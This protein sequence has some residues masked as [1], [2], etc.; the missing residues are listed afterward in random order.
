MARRKLEGTERAEQRR[1]TVRRYRARL[2]A[3]GEPSDVII[4][5]PNGEKLEVFQKTGLTCKKLEIACKK[6]FRVEG[7]ISK[8]GGATEFLMMEHDIIIPGTYAYF[9]PPPAGGEC[10]RCDRCARLDTRCVTP[11]INAPHCFQCVINGYRCRRDGGA[12]E[13]MLYRLPPAPRIVDG[14]L[15]M[16]IPQLE[17]LPPDPVLTG[18]VP[19]PIG[20]VRGV[21]PVRRGDLL[22]QLRVWLKGVDGKNHVC[23]ASQLDIYLVLSFII[24]GVITTAVD[25]V[26]LMQYPHLSAARKKLSSLTSEL[27]LGEWFIGK[28]A[29]L[30]AQPVAG[31]AVPAPAPRVDGL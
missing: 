27:P 29:A 31:G 18:G 24:K 10:S 13:R 9:I 5:G 25:D 7:V 28:P 23:L 19:D 30:P 22:R 11:P 21:I 12:E 3:R 26:I 4:Y 15:A 14:R 6:R 2:K 17:A 8:L 1:L 16:E 20:E